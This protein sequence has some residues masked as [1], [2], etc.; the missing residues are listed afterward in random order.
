MLAHLFLH[1]RLSEIREFTFLVIWS[2]LTAR[3]VFEERGAGKEK[4]KEQG[5]MRGYSGNVAVTRDRRDC[6]RK[7]YLLAK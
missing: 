1:A 5:P 3:N 4:K 6:E 2:F 7:T